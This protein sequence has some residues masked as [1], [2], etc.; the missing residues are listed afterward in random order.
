MWGN[1]KHEGLSSFHLKTQDRTID[2]NSGE[3][4]SHKYSELI[5]RLHVPREKNQ[6]N[7][8]NLNL[9][10]IPSRIR[11]TLVNK[12]KHRL[13]PSILDRVNPLSYY[14]RHLS[15]FITG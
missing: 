12:N 2:W 6:E 1:D 3:K 15:L 5:I 9:V 11:E 10:S 4:Q 8:T 7:T 13:N 14:L